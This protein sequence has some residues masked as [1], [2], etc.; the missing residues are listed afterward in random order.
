MR[1]SSLASPCMDRGLNKDKMPSPTPW[2]PLVIN[3]AVP[4]TIN[5]IKAIARI[6]IIIRQIH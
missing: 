2:I 3:D 5:G 6:I 1:P 4:E